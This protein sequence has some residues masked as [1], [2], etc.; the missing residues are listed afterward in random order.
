MLHMSA[1]CYE[2]RFGYCTNVKTCFNVHFRPILAKRRVLLGQWRS[3]KPNLSKG[4]KARLG[5]WNFAVRD[6]KVKS[7]GGKLWNLCDK[8]NPVART[9][10][11][12]WSYVVDVQI[13]SSSWRSATTP[14]TSGATMHRETSSALRSE[15]I[16]S[17]W[18]AGTLATA[19]TNCS[20]LTDDHFIRFHFRHLDPHWGACGPKRRPNWTTNLFTTAAAVTP[21]LGYNVYKLS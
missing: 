20:R 18:R 11:R 14:S 21:R 8:S 3:L 13:M 5:L 17:S 9:A 19:G 10:W 15:P 16:T 2:H 6:R 1:Q 12:R 4:P 7:S